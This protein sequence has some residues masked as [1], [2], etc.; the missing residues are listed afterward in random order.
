MER[1]K[2]LFVEYQTSGKF[3]LKFGPSPHPHAS[4]RRLIQ[5]M[6]KRE[7]SHKNDLMGMTKRSKK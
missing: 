2:L 1:R 3:D 6:K 4:L 7:P 5:A